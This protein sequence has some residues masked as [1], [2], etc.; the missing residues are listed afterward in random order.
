MKTKAMAAIL[1]KIENCLL[2]YIQFFHAS[3]IIQRH[4]S[5]SIVST[6]LPNCLEKTLKINSSIFECLLSSF[7]L[8]K[9]FRVKSP[10]RLK[11]YTEIQGLVF[12]LDK[13]SFISKLSS[14]ISWFGHQHVDKKR[15]NTSAF[16]KIQITFV[17]LVQIAADIKNN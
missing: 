13:N 16:I 2:F 4:N 1:K 17:N 9:C 5:I 14:S 3:I 12:I 15:L 8:V 6:H 11:H 10:H 7:Y